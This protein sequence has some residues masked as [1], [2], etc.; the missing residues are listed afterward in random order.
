MEFWKNTDVYYN[1]IGSKIEQSIEGLG[2]IRTIKSL[3]ELDSGHMT[4]TAL[5][6]TVSEKEE[7]YLTKISNLGG[8]LLIKSIFNGMNSY[9]FIW[10]DAIV[11]MDFNLGTN[12]INISAFGTNE[13]IIITLKKMCED[14]FIT[15]A[16]QGYIFAIM[17]QGSSLQLQRIGYAGTQLEKTNYSAK[18]ISDYDYVIKDLKSPQPSGRISIFDGPPGTGKTYLVRSI[19]TSVPDA[20]FVLVPPNMVSALGGPE[21]LPM[22]LQH[23]E[24]YKKPG[25]TVFIL[26]D[27]DQCLVP[28]GPDNIDSISA[29]LN[30][31]DGIFGSLFD[32]RIVATTNAKKAEMDAAIIRAGR[33]SKRVE[34]GKLNYDEASAIYQRLLPNETMPRI[35]NPEEYNPM[36]PHGGD[37][38]YSLAEVYKA[39]RDA[40]WEPIALDRDPELGDAEIIDDEDYDEDYDDNGDDDD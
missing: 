25:P 37:N 23:K 26:E 34:V 8:R 20:L 14:T 7:Y 5:S 24:S 30:L 27:A 31:G 40:G 18:I 36:K 6:G 16:K 21:L 19:L 10:N 2:Y 28:R 17:R 13:E 4:K 11:D 29:I 9:I 33:L 22:L 3:L 1:T 15:P 35:V 32:I 39:A 38:K 12:H